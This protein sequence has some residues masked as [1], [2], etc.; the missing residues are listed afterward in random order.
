MTDTPQTPAEKAEAA[1]IRRRWITL[2]EVVAIAGLIISALALWSSW[3]ERRADDT[4]RRVE[5]QREIKAK[6]AVLLTGTPR[7]GGEEL[8]VSD[9]AHPIQGI[10]V[11][12][13]T[14]LGLSPQTSAPSPIIS[15]R[16][17]AAKLMTLTDGGPDE[18]TGRLPVLIA[19]DYWDGDQ[20]ITD[21]A[22]YD[23]VWRTH[24]RMLLGRSLRLEGMLLRERGKPDQARVDALW[25]KV[26]PAPKH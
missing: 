6:T 16:W 26:A 21:R 17:F 25:S 23:L 4:Q 7:R 22:V 14:A 18:Q 3:A 15:V 5:K 13:P 9:L 10:T 2:G 8:A 24:G 20:H 11:T 19:S 12:F 1:A